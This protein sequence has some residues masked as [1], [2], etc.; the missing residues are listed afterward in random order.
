MTRRP[1]PPDEVI[2]ETVHGSRLY[3]FSHAGSDH[4]TFTVTTSR[5]PRSQQVIAGDADMLTVGVGRFVTLVMQGS[6]QAVEALF[7]TQKVWGKNAA[8]D[9]VRPMLEA[10]RV[11][12]P[13]VVARY[14]RTVKAF[15]FGNFKKRR[16]AVRLAMNLAALR[17]DG[18]MDP[19]LP[20]SDRAL[21]A[22]LAE[23]MEGRDL[24]GYLYDHIE[25]RPLR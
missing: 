12:G 22:E 14:Q 18:V 13:E 4:D 11:T 23:H 15:C 7:S 16:H 6:H 21:A 8:A 1:R 25:G 24:L 17:R 9:Q 5:W 20:E 19:T 10:V 3:G 2:F